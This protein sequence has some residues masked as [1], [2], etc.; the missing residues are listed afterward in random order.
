MI[1]RKD[2][3]QSRC[4]QLCAIAYTKNRHNDTDTIEIYPEY[5]T[6]IH[7]GAFNHTERASELLSFLNKHIQTSVIISKDSIP[8]IF[9]TP[10]PVIPTSALGGA[11]T[12]S[13]VSKQLC[14]IIWKYIWKICG[15]PAQLFPRLIHVHSVFHLYLMLFKTICVFLHCHQIAFSYPGVLSY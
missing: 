4:K 7:F 3:I 11:M 14:R 15:I 12:T 5:L 13:P 8:M 1:T 6:D 2:S 10:A 9:T